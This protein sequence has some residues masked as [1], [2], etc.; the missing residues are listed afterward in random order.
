LRES[1]AALD[2][3]SV[4]QRVVQFSRIPLRSLLLHFA[5]E[6][7]RRV[8]PAWAREL[9]DADDRSRGALVATLRAYAN[10][11]MNVLKAAEALAVHPNTIYARLQR[12]CDISGL[13]ARSFNALTEL[14]IV[15]DATRRDA[16][17][18]SGHAD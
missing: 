1:A 2:L 12:I 9:E 5:G 16:A 13:Q 3:A 17:E 8:L 15:C 4:T 14:L 7:F 10:A 11:D 6:D 18:V